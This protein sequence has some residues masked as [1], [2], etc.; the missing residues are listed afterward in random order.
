MDNQLQRQ[1]QEEMDREARAERKIN[2]GLKRV[3]KNFRQYKLVNTIDE[4]EIVL[5]FNKKDTE[6]FDVILIDDE[7]KQ[8]IKNNTDP[9]NVIFFI[10]HKN[11]RNSK[12][13]ALADISKKRFVKTK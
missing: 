11:N 12:I 3:L 8:A 13:Q 1:I 7:V 5:I 10:K 4:G 2:N 9:N 6:Y